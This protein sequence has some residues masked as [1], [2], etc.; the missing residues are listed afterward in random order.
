MR[1]CIR[2]GEVRVL[3]DKFPHRDVHDRIDH[4]R[5]YLASHR[6]VVPFGY[7]EQF[8]IGLG[9]FEEILYPLSAEIVIQYALWIR[10]LVG[11]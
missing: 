9:G 8:Q 7:G 10:I 2:H 1:N 11:D 4:V 3:D 6:A 5:K